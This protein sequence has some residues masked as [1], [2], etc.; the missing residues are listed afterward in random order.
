[1]KKIFPAIAF[2]FVSLFCFSCATT[3]N[4]NVERPAEIDLASAQS[5]AIEPIT[6]P[7]RF[8]SFNFDSRDAVAYLE[9]NLVTKLSSNGTY[10][11]VPPTDRVTPA[12]VLLRF[13]I[14]QF[15]IDE[16]VRTEKVKNKNYNKDKNNGNRV[17]G[18]SEYIYEKY[19]RR[20]VRFVYR[21]QFING[22]T[23]NVIASREREYSSKSSEE[24][25]LSR[26]PSGY[27]M[28]RSKLDE[29]ITGI[30]REVFPYTV[31][32]TLTLLKDKSKNPDM[33]YADKLADK[34]FLVESAEAFDNIYKETG[35]FEAGYN[36]GIL[37]EA[38]GLYYLAE[39]RMTFL[40]NNY[41][42]E[43]ALNAL[44]DIKNEIDQKKRLDNQKKQHRAR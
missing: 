23:N 29:I 17:S 22:Q 38:L 24:R 13:E 8:L 26:L 28:I 44:S 16:D 10:K 33:E 37:Y 11:V 39:E 15:D 25:S 31:S 14:L 42:D 5:I 30:G 40:W 41:G 32:K 7:S 6:Y 43:R 36:A 9:R 18:A 21:Y 2:V 27:S 34:G 1:M 19:Y 35:L 20:S 4:M 12:D 3:V